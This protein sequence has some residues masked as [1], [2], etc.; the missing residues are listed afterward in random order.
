MIPSNWALHPSSPHWTRAVLPCAAALFLCLGAPELDAQS[1]GQGNPEK[2]SVEARAVPALPAVRVEG[3]PPVIDGDLSDSAWALAPVATSFVQFD[4][5]E[6]APASQ[7]TEVRVLYDDDALYV[8]FRA[9][10]SDPSEIRAQLTRRDVSSSSDQVHVLI[11]SYHDRRT[12]FHFAVN[13]LGVKMDLYRYDDTG[14]DLSWNAVWDVATRIDEEGWTAEFR[15]PLSQLRYSGSEEQ[16]WGIN[17]ARD[18]ARLNETSVWA[19]LSRDEQA[20]VSRSGELRGLSGLGANR[21][22]EVLPYTVARATRAPGDPENPFHESTAL[23]GEMGADLKFGITNNMTLDLTVN[24]D[25]GQVEADPAQVNLTAFETFLPEQRPFFVEGAGI[26]RFGIGIGDGDGGN[27]SLF[28]SRRIGRAPQG[29]FQPRDAWVDPPSQTRILAAGKLSGK[30][31]GGWSI[32]VLNALTGN[33]EARAIHHDGTHDRQVVEPLTSYSM[34]R[35]QRDFRDGG[36][37]VGGTVTGTIRDESGAAD[38]ALRDLALSG[39]IDARH[40]FRDGTLEIRGYLLG[41]RVSGSTEAIRRTQRSSA[42][43]LQRPDNTHTEYDE[44]RTALEGWSTTVEM[45]KVGGG[46]WR[47]GSISQIRSPGFEVNDLG[48]MSGADRIFQAGWVGYRQNRPGTHLR[49]WGVNSNLWSGW[50]FGGEHQDM[51]G[52]L[53]GNLAL[54]NNWNAYAGVA[55]NGSTLSPTLLRGGPMFRVERGMNGWG[56]VNTDS[57]R[58]VQGNVNM[59]W[60]VRPESD[61][62]NLNTSTSLRWRPS[63]RATIRTGPFHNRRVE[64]RQWLGTTGS[65][66]DPIYLFGRLEQRTTGVTARVD[67][68]VSPT[69]SFQLYAQPFLSTGHF[70]EMRRVGDPRGDTYRDRMV[71]LATTRGEDGSIVADPEGDGT[72]RSLGNPDFSVGQFRSNAVVRWEYRPGSTLFVVWSQGRDDRDTDGTLGVGEGFGN[73]FDRPAE[74]RLMVKLNYW[75]SP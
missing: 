3:A 59:N 72:A 30:T 67:F 60:G 23:G 50:T 21:R 73:L 49:G 36:S 29:H 75:L 44:D 13:P 41:S 18:I 31:E 63:G 2:A 20:V 69:L 11:D 58:S 10:E 16:T 12:A 14:E 15:I 7:P 57:R 28:Y 39:G 52:N 35:V 19:P 5:D 54:N 62:W 8:A 61:S 25:F 33:A 6:G 43:Y 74:N 24:P 42:R 27:E 48:F 32:G 4:P 1:N 53:N 66:E 65:A 40:R 55:L 51:G 64:D 38:L 17:F 9:W 46:P 37:A 56:G 34:A 70:T 26:F 47:F 68:A 45:M 71:P 22:L